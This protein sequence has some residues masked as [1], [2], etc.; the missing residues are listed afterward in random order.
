[1]KRRLRKKLQM[2]EFVVYGFAVKANL[3]AVGRAGITLN[4]RAFINNFLAYCDYLELGFG[5][6]IG[7]G[8]HAVGGLY[9]Y[10]TR[11][12]GT[13]T[14]HSD[15]SMLRSYL[16]AKDADD[17]GLGLVTDVWVGPFVDGNTFSWDAPAKITRPTR[18]GKMRRRRR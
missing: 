4:E 13:S 3:H 9:G 15:R 2:G 14:D 18:A 16:Q 6:S 7:L 8:G 10:V 11:T 12:D 1:M 17:N 5:G